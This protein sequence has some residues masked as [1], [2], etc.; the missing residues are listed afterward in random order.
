MAFGAIN[1]DL[2]VLVGAVKAPPMSMTAVAMRDGTLELVE[3]PIP[4]PGP[5]EVLVK[6]SPPPK[7]WLCRS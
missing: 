6:T 2:D 5:G 3:T 1:T 7:A 4:Q